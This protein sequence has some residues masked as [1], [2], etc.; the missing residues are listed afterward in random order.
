MNNIS[1]PTL[2][3]N[4]KLDP[5]AFTLPMIGEV[6]WYGIII[7]LGIILAFLYCCHVAKKEGI[8]S[9]T[10]A[11][12]LI[13]ALPV[14]VICARTYYVVFSWEQ[15]RDNLADVF[16]IWEGGIAI[17]GAIIGAIITGIVFCRV[18]KLD[19]LK[20]FDICC[21]GLMIG[22]L[23]GRW[24]NFVNAEAFGGYCKYFWGMS[25]EGKECVHPTF[26]Y[27]SLWNIL[28]F[29]ILSLLHKK[30]PFYGF[31]FF[32]YTSW[33]GLGRFFIEGLR[34]DS[35]YFGRIRVSEALALICV[36]IGISALFYLSRRNISTKK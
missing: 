1:F 34:S 23:V 12:L 31:T 30:R 21:L 7:G 18:K 4:L 17:Y 29:M 33:Y 20:I 6:H 9:D 15:Y 5:V 22:Q 36:F 25:I 14:S 24:G 8:S 2:G 10:I 26:L 19:T 13:Y 32:S 28:G 11:D 16:K 27:E 35:L 3:I